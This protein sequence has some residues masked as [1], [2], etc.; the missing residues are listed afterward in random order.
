MSAVISVP[1]PRKFRL[2]FRKTRKSTPIVDRTNHNDLGANRVVYGQPQE[3]K[4][5]KTRRAGQFIQRNAV[6][7][8]GFLKRGAVRVGRAIMRGAGGVAVGITAV[9]RAALWVLTWAVGIVVA[10]VGVVALLAVC[11]VAAVVSLIA[12]VLGLIGKVLLYLHDLGVYFA[13]GRPAAGLSKT[14]SFRLYRAYKNVD[15]YAE[16]EKAA[17][18]RNAWMQQLAEDLV[19]R[20]EDLSTEESESTGLGYPEY[21]ESVSPIVSVSMPHMQDEGTSV[22]ENTALDMEFFP[23]LDDPK[24]YDWAKHLDDPTVTEAYDFFAERCFVTDDMKGYSYW[25]ARSYARSMVPTLGWNAN[26][27]H[28]KWC[29]EINRNDHDTRAGW[30]GVKDEVEMLSSIKDEIAARIAAR[31]STSSDKS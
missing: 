13:K 5:S 12:W 31:E 18:D 22:E 6:R 8:G 14:R 26:K 15:R 7:T 11:I 17:E 28:G 24:S 27:I 20:F 1:G 10:L 4:V 23:A 9:L 29:G 25:T 2:F 3:M 19:A 16:A 30:E 21:D